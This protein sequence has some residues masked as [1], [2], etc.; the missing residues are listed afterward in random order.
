MRVS[1]SKALARQHA[2]TFSSS[3]PQVSNS[4]SRAPAGSSWAISAAASAW[5]APV[6]G[7]LRSTVCMTAP[8]SRAALNATALSPAA[9]A[10]KARANRFHISPC[11]WPATRAI[12]IAVSSTSAAS[13][14]RP[15][16][17]RAVPV[18]NSV[19]KRLTLA[20]RL[21]DGQRA[22]GVRDPRS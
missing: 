10:V 2:G 5:P 14:R 11:S 12:S 15:T 20:G 13:R 7:K 9:S 22:L 16:I 8:A 21:G 4:T 6:V 19:G 1:S 17:V 18:Q 3:S